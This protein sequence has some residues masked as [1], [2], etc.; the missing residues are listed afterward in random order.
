RLLYPLSCVGPQRFKL[1]FSFRRIIPNV[2]LLENMLH[3]EIVAIL[4]VND[5]SNSPTNPNRT[6]R[7]KKISFSRLPPF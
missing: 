1:T 4:H 7:E 5:A 6:L 3:A 2:D